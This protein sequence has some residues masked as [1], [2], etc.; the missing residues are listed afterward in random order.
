MIIQYQLSL[1]FFSTHYLVN[2]GDNEIMKKHTFSFTASDNKIEIYRSHNGG[3]VK[4]LLINP[5]SPDLVMELTKVI[6]LWTDCN[7][8]VSEISNLLKHHSII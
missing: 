7:Y 8:S 1:T 4:S 3:L 6:N 5:L 2:I